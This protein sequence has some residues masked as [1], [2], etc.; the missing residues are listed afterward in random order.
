MC[1]GYE[2]P[3]LWGIARLILGNFKL[4]LFLWC[5]FYVI[6]GTALAAI[7]L[8]ITLLGFFIQPS[9]LSVNG[10]EAGKRYLVIQQPKRSLSVG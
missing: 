4:A 7:T 2:G 3:E 5:L 1:Y 6:L 8:K 10:A 9:S